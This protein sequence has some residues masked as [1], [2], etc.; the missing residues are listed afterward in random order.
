MVDWT[1]SMQQTFEYYIVDPISWKDTR[2]I[3]TILSSKLSKDST[4]DTL[5]SASLTTTEMLGE[6]YIRVYLITFQNGVKEKHPLG[7]YMVQSPSYSFDGKIRTLRMDGYTPL[8]E[9]KEKKPP[10]GYNLRKNDNILD[11]AYSILRDNM[12]APTIKTTKSD[13]LYHNFVA[14]IDDTWI[15]FVKDLLANAKSHLMLDE[16]GRVIFEPDQ[17]MTAMQP[18]WTFDDGN[19]S[20]LYANFDMDHDLY[21]IPNEVEVIY[22]KSS[23]V[24][25]AVVRNDDPN[26]PVSTINRGRIISHRI[27][28]PEIPGSPSKEQVSIYAKQ[29]LKEMSRIGYTVT[30]THGYCPVRIGDCVRLN[31][32]AAGLNNVKAKVIS[33]SI[34]CV[35]GC[36]VTEKAVFI[37]ELWAGTKRSEGVWS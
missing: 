23:T 19:S 8:I 24:Y 35:P 25:S 18:V 20:I 14:N 5:G 15:E 10:M 22:S 3:D 13:I 37:D 28:N 27:T 26:S 4:N 30:Y 21:G 11:K 32:E 31:C 16:M 12:R 33:Q 29:V 1:A 7:T 9:L 6:C 36:P 34:E 17:D 2:K